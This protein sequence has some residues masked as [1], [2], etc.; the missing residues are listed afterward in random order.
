MPSSIPDWVPS[1]A[2]VGV[3][4][5]AFVYCAVMFVR[6]GNRRL[7]GILGD[8]PAAYRPRAEL[9]ARVV[10]DQLVAREVNRV[11]DPELERLA[12]LYVQAVADAEDDAQEA[13]RHVVHRAQSNTRHRP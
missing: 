10:R 2:G 3:M 11:L 4:T 1:L 8:V 13:A 12:P 6:S 9:E 5:V 7:K